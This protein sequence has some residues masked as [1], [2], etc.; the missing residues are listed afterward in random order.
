MKTVLCY[1]DSITWGYNPEDAS[2][3]EFNE[4]W[5]GILQGEL[6]DSVRVIE[7][8]LPGRTTNS[9]RPYLPDRNGSTCLPM[10]LEAHA[11]I[12][13][14]I[15][16]LGTNDL[17]KAFGFSASDIAASCMS[18]IW[19]VQKSMAGPGYGVP[20]IL[21]IAPPKLGKLSTFMSFYLEGRQKASS[22]L[23]REYKKAAEVSACHFLDASKHVRAS[24]IDGV[25]S[26][27][28]SLWRSGI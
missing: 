24:K 3:F 21:L 2:R 15:L 9:D 25:P 7:E 27:E 26:K 20:E 16:M 10:I 5:P 23:A 13:V 8:S 14:F 4:R 28:N 12:D 19:K 22:E 6:G 18:L 11:P 1:G 17:F